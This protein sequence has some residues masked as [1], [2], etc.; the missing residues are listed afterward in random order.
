MVG[1][2][3]IN[4]V[5]ENVME[6]MSRGMRVKCMQHG[7]NARIQNFK[8]SVQFLALTPLTFFVKH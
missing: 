2:K 3:Q 4:L 8:S 1:T 7:H 6:Q 5:I